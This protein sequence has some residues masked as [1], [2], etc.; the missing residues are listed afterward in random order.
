MPDG[1]H[2]M[3]LKTPSG[4]K[5]RSVIE[6][7]IHMQRGRL[8]EAQAIVDCVRRSTHIETDA[9]VNLALRAAFDA[10]GAIADEL[11]LIA[12]DART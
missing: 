1:T 3:P 5:K 7:R 9:S 11:E 2:S 12:I 8:F 4:S 10:L 6:D